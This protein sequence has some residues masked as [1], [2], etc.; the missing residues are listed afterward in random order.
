VAPNPYWQ[1]IGPAPGEWETR[2][3][4]AAAWLQGARAVVD[5]GCGAMALE[6]HLVPGQGYIPVDLVARDARTL[7]VDLDQDPLPVVDADA[8]ALL[9]VLGY[10]SDPEAM[11]RKVRA[12][13]PRVVLSYA[14]VPLTGAKLARGRRNSLSPL[15]LRRLIAEVGFTVVREG[16]LPSNELLFDLRVTPP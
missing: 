13:F 16:R 4:V 2:A 9:G 8:C 6:R 14:S 5:L 15:E 3:R 10:L 11:L 7:V 12:A 1:T